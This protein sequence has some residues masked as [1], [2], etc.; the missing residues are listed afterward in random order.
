M[1][2]KKVLVVCGTGGITSTVAEREIQAA[3]RQAGIPIQTMRCTPHEV[4][5]RAGDV[6]LIVSTT[7]LATGFKAP[8]INGIA[9]ITGVGKKELIDKIIASLKS[10]RQ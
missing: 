1:E 10:E 7:A 5:A 8:V 2:T 4:P 3:A 9:F 6:D